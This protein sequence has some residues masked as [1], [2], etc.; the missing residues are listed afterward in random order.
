[1]AFSP[2][3]T[4]LASCSWEDNG[5]RVW[6]SETGQELLTLNHNEKGVSRVLFSPDGHR[7]AITSWD[8]TVMIWDATPLPAK[9]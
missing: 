4:R 2:D 5:V 3:G 9:R 6:D 8:G 7:V 1:V